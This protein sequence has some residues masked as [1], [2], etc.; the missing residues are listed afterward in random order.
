M[1]KIIC[2]LLCAVL[3]W[4]AIGPAMSAEVT[5]EPGTETDSGDSTDTGDGGDSSDTGDSPGDGGDSSDTG[6]TDENGDPIEEPSD[7]IPLTAPSRIGWGR[8]YRFT[9]G[10]YRQQNP[11]RI[12]TDEYGNEYVDCPGMMYWSVDD[13]NQ[14]RYRLDLFKQDPESGNVLLETIEEWK[15]SNEGGFESN[16]RFLWTPRESGDYFFAVRAIG[17]G[18]IYAD[19]D[20]AQSNV[21]TYET[22][23][24]Q[25][26]QPGRPSWKGATESATAFIYPPSDTDVDPYTGLVGEA[27]TDNI[28]RMGYAS[29]W[30]FVKSLEED[31]SGDSGDS[32]NSDDTKPKE[33]GT[34]LT[35]YP[36]HYEFK[37]SEKML[38]DYGGGY[39]SVQVC[40]LSRNVAQA[41]PSVWSPLSMALYIPADD[42][43]LNT[44][45]NRVDRNT[46]ALNRQLAINNVRRFGTFKLTELMAADKYDTGAVAAI[47]QL[48]RITGNTAEVRVSGGLDELFPS[49]KI[50]AVGAG[51][52][53]DLGQKVIFHLGKAQADE[54]P[55]TL[56]THAVRFS[57]QLLDTNGVSLTNGPDELKVPVKITLPVPDEINPSFFTI[58]HHRTDSIVE[59]DGTVKENVEVIPHVSLRK[60]DGQWFA[61]FIVTHFSDF[62]MAEQA[63]FVTAKRTDGGVSVSYR[64]NAPQVKAALCAVREKS[65]RL[66]AVAALTPSVT[67][68]TVTIAC[69]G[70]PDDVKLFLL[71]AHSSP[72]LPSLTQ[73]VTD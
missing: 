2:L 13:D 47:A 22:P 42:E 67:Q 45:V 16:F 31:D 30:W 48:E 36:K 4:S 66:C 37:P 55:S 6:A 39:Y 26:S 62:T 54:V 41:K 28:Y 60:V 19:S 17:D 20:T 34:I 50:S 63:A 14:R 5:P 68:K 40:A 51:L 29:K 64:M 8:D 23:E 52:N 3:F 15:V 53:L 56:Y 73:A 61:S 7:P 10:Y 59:D 35:F 71:D 11:D 24:K 27:T 12:K 65:G 70:D 49:G 58:L 21:W 25:L 32:Q 43:D 38:T 9:L 18:T 44:I 69:N 1:K 33:I 57:M 46:D 72:V